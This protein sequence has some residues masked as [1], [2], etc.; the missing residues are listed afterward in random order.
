[1][2]ANIK[3]CV[4]KDKTGQAVPLLFQNQKG[5][6]F[7]SVNYCKYCYNV[8]YQKEPLFLGKMD[9]LWE[10]WGIPSIRYVFTT[11]GKRETADVL[12]G[13]VAEKIQTGHFEYGIV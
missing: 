12:S 6:E 9:I 7:L 1:M 8:I 10:E 3:E 11:E 5:K 2:Y 4:C 13:R